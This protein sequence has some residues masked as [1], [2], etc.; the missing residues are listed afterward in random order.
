[1]AHIK[2]AR[3]VVLTA[4]GLTGTFIISL[5]GKLSVAKAAN[6]S[7]VATVAQQQQLGVD[8]KQ[9]FEKPTTVVRSNRPQTLTKSPLRS[10]QGYEDYLSGCEAALQ[11][12][13]ELD[14][15]CSS[16]LMQNEM[17]EKIDMLTNEVRELKEAIR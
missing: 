7:V 13:R 9:R 1:M 15:E 10:N 3:R 5:F 2:R 14:K 11:N 4:L 17:M 16:F 12:N 6:G 8:T